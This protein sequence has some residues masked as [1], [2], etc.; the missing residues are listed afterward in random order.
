MNIFRNS[1]KKAV[2]F[3]DGIVP[4]EGTSASE[5]DDQCAESNVDKKKQK[6]KHLYRRKQAKRNKALSRLGSSSQSKLE[7]TDK[8]NYLIDEKV[9][10]YMKLTGIPNIVYK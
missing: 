8:E 7:L 4:G 9:Y 2:K 3:S 1:I 5:N 10:I 6:K